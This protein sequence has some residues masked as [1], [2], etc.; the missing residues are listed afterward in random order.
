MSERLTDEQRAYASMTERLTDEEY[1]AWIDAG[2]PMQ[3]DMWLRFLA[4]R[5][6]LEEA[7]N[8]VPKEG[9]D[10]IASIYAVPMPAHPD[11]TVIHAYSAKGCW[12][13]A[14]QLPNDKF[15]TIVNGSPL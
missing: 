2:S 15:D 13:G 11:T 8:H 12:I 1:S 9:E 4:I 5:E 3:V 6:A 10:A 14:A 7:K